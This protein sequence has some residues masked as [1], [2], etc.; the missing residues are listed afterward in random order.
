[1]YYVLS[2]IRLCQIAALLL[3]THL[4]ARKPENLAN[5]DQSYECMRDSILCFHLHHRYLYF[6]YYKRLPDREI[7][8]FPR[9]TSMEI[10][11]WWFNALEYNLIKNLNLFKWKN[12][13]KF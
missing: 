7:I 10:L 4:Q 6:Y 8:D 13:N 2:I 3:K 9:W 11:S 12:L 5:K 1:M